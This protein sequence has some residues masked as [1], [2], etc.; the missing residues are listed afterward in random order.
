VHDELCEDEDEDQIDDGCNTLSS[1]PPPQV[2]F[3]PSSP[4]CKR[5]RHDYLDDN[6]GRTTHL[7]TFEEFDALPIIARGKTLWNHQLYESRDF[8]MKKTE[9][10]RL[11]LNEA[12][13][14]LKAL[15][16]FYKSFSLTAKSK[17]RTSSSKVVK[18]PKENI[19]TR[20]LS[21]P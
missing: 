7:C 2:P 1:L 19:F 17:N 5:Q 9:V 6:P 14:S 8:W 12:F 13:G 16:Y 11:V 18:T 4:E 3:Y 21:Q 15:F 10:W 20:M